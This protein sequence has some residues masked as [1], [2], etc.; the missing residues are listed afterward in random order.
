MDEGNGTIEG[1]KALGGAP[2]IEEKSV[3]PEGAIKLDDGRVLTGKEVLALERG[4]KEL[5]GQFTGETTI[6]A[7]KRKAVEE[8]M[9]VLEVEKAKMAKIPEALRKDLEWYQSHSKEPELWDTYEAETF[10]L[11]EEVG[12][13]ITKPNPHEEMLI[14]EVRGLT[15]E[16]K[17][18]RRQSAEKDVD[19]KV[20]DILMAIN[21]AHGKYPGAS[22]RATHDWARLY[23]YENG[24]KLPG[25]GDV[26][27]YMAQLH[28]DAVKDGWKMPEKRVDGEVVKGKKISAKVPPD[29]EGKKVPSI[30][31]RTAF[32]RASEE[33]WA[34]YDLRRQNA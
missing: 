9:K 7:R 16:V 14:K 26:L 33:W 3:V 24:D 31:D 17:S 21:E 8:G 4:Y 19:V 29:E 1:E 6:L 28:E 13:P 20:D 10:K 12:I 22:L 2:L 23:A 32:S 5:Q 11:S 27:K 18:L 15:D 30:N 25:K 34:R